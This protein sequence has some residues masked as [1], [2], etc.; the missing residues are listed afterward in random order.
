M[1]VVKKYFQRK[2]GAGIGSIINILFKQAICAR[3]GLVARRHCAYCSGVVEDD[4]RVIFLLDKE[5]LWLCT[6]GEKKQPLEK[7]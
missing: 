5:G 3:T 7:N 6:V 1:N 4:S 2:K